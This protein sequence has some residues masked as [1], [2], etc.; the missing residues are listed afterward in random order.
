MDESDLLKR[1]ENFKLKR[2]D[3]ILLR[4]LK[5]LGEEDVRDQVLI[6]FTLQIN[7]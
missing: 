3:F 2:R 1:M 7:F 4:Y 5:I 6:T